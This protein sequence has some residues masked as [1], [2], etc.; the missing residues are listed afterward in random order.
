MSRE[1]TIKEEGY[2]FMYVSNENATLVDVY[3]DD[4]VMTHTKGNVVQY[5]EYY[6]FGL[7]TAN[8]W[9]R[10]NNTG[11]NF[12][13]NGGT[14]LNTTS[15]LYDLHYRNYDPVLGRMNQV[16][17]MATKYA[18]LSPYNFSFNDPVNFN[19]PL[20]DDAASD[21]KEKEGQERAARME[22]N[23]QWADGW[24][25]NVRAMYG[26]VGDDDLFPKGGIGGGNG[27]ASHQEYVNAHLAAKER[28][29]RVEYNSGQY[30][31]KVPLQTTIYVA[32]PDD[33][34]YIGY[35][36]TYTW[37]G[38]AAIAINQTKPFPIGGVLRTTQVG[39][40]LYTGWSIG[41]TIGTNIDG[42]SRSVAGLLIKLG[43]PAEKLISPGYGNPK[44]WVASK[45]RAKTLVEYEGDE[46][47]FPP[48]NEKTKHGALL[49]LRVTG[50]L[51][52]LNELGIDNAK[53]IKNGVQ[54]GISSTKS[55]FSDLK[56]TT[57][58]G[59]SDIE[60][61]LKNGWPRN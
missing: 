27:S 53:M 51:V 15:N 37:A 7:Q 61:G 60:N 12:L 54:S 31:I 38:Q 34:N 9:T 23:R 49:L 6:P 45:G 19:D 14:E 29:G 16:D 35:N 33:E 2:V 18:S 21:K 1:Y 44:D 50:V 11:N 55:F 59:F 20:G 24:R 5:N 46:N 43:A 39:T 28:N 42:F 13:A 56:N 4:I 41:A 52:S 57:M 36:L 30:W 32:T 26:V 17:P 10:E 47:H 22:A 40:A 58:Q 3:F 25:A 8:S 48:N